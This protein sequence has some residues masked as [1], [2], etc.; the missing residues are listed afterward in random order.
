MNIRTS[1]NF[2]SFFHPRLRQTVVLAASLACL[3]PSIG[4]AFAPAERSRTGAASGHPETPPW[5]V[6]ENLG[7]ITA[8][9]FQGPAQTV[10]YIEDLHCQYEVQQ[11]IAALLEYLSGRWKIGLIGL[12]GASGP[13]DLGSLK[14]FPNRTLRAL[15]ANYFMR[16]GRLTGAEFFAVAQ[17]EPVELVGL[18]SPALYAEALKTA[19]TCL[20]SENQGMLLDLRER[21]WKYR[22]TAP[23]LRRER[24]DV[25]LGRVELANKLLNI[26]ATPREWL[27]FQQHRSEYD[28]A[29][30]TQ[31][32][33][34]P[35]GPGPAEDFSFSGL[36][37]ALAQAEKFYRISDQRSRVL[38]GQLEQAIKIRP[39][40]PAVLIGGGFHRDRVL[41]ELKRRGFN[42]ISIQ[43]RLSGG[44]TPNPYFQI[45]QG[46][47]TELEKAWFGAAGHLAPEIW[48]QADPAGY[49][50]TSEGLLDVLTTAAAANPPQAGP[51]AGATV[52]QT[53][54]QNGPARQRGKWALILDKKHFRFLNPTGLRGYAEFPKWFILFFKEREEVNQALETL[55]RPGWVF[56]GVGLGLAFLGRFTESFSEAGAGLFSLLP[57]AK[58]MGVPGALALALA[59]PAP[60]ASAHYFGPGMK[61]PV[62]EFLKHAGGKGRSLLEMAQMK[63]PVPPGFVIQD[64]IS[65]RVI[66][67]NGGRLSSGLKWKFRAQMA[68]VNRAAK[69]GFGD[70][71][72]PLLVSVRSGAD[73]SMPGMMQTLTHVGLN[74]ETVKGWEQQTGNPDYAWDSYARYIRDFGTIVFRIPQEKFE[75][76][77]RGLLVS[78][79]SKHLGKEDAQ[80]LI[81]KYQGVIR[82]AGHAFPQD[83]YE[84]LFLAV[85]RVMNS[86][87]DQRVRDFRERFQIGDIGTGVTVQE[88]VFG[89]SNQQSGS[90]VAYSRDP[91]SGAKRMT[92]N[93]KLRQRGEAIVSGQV[94]P[95]SL[96][97]IQQEISEEVYRQLASWAV[98]L[99]KKYRKILDIEFTIENGRLF[100]LQNRSAENKLSPEAKMIVWRDML[101]ETLI[102]EDEFFD[103]ITSS[104][105]L[106]ME[107]YLRSPRVP[108]N[109]SQAPAAKGEKAAVGIQAGKL[110]FGLAE[111]EACIRVG[112]RFILAVKSSGPEHDKVIQNPL[113]AGVIEQF[114][115][116]FSHAAA[117]LRGSEA[118]KPCVSGLAR[119]S[120]FSFAP[121]A[122]YIDF[123]RAGTH[124]MKGDWLTVDGTTGKIY[125]GDITDRLEAS[126]VQ[127]AIDEPM[128]QAAESPEYALYRMVL[129]WINEYKDR[130][131]RQRLNLDANLEQWFADPAQKQEWNQDFVRPLHYL[132]RFYPALCTR[133]HKAFILAVLNFWLNR[134]KVPLANYEEGVYPKEE[135]LAPIEAWVKEYFQPLGFSER[136]LALRILYTLDRQTFFRFITAPGKNHAY[137]LGLEW[138]PSGEGILKES[139]LQALAESSPE[140]VKETL[141]HASRNLA[142]YNLEQYL[143]FY[144]DNHFILSRWISLIPEPQK[145]VDV[146]CRLSPKAL[147]N[148]SYEW[149]LGVNMMFGSD[150]LKYDLTAVGEIIGAALERW[151]QDFPEGVERF[152]KEISLRDGQFEELAGQGQISEDY[153]NGLEKKYGAEALQANWPTLLLKEAGVVFPGS[154]ASVLAGGMMPWL[155]QI[156]QMR[157]GW[158]ERQ[159]AQRAWWVEGAPLMALMSFLTVGVLLGWIDAGRAAEVLAYVNVIYWGAFTPAHFLKNGTWLSWRHMDNREKANAGIAL[160]LSV[161]NIAVAVLG[162]AFLGP[163]AWVSGVV[164]GLGSHGAVN[165]IRAA[166]AKF[167]RGPSKTEKLRIRFFPARFGRSA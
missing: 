12:E 100:L 164:F 50:E 157:W 93:W 89:D 64:E 114:G 110:V 9:Y 38:V 135:E 99:E 37:Q 123:D 133:E 138:G 63:L 91:I 108:L 129:G 155:R 3:L 66:R 75:N 105:L 16:Q 143:H 28:S 102:T 70:R 76:E 19:R 24:A 71:H 120:E 58:G 46:R 27:Q 156:A 21:L 33:Q 59:Q 51:M 22:E 43:P 74:D 150:Y 31:P 25:L 140:T 14:T 90:G 23:P 125:Y 94:S 15:A 17:P 8:R 124:T 104:E 103:H 84:Q 29:H 40:F 127:E 145:I 166:V 36:D 5:N 115:A 153:F 136:V 57:A 6:P 139:M 82:A 61:K 32:F 122:E 131:H 55:N 167:R 73:T 11:T 67:E 42:F 35:S 117:L 44:N 159:Y 158:S 101:A 62:P 107:H 111:A 161:L 146:L 116:T 65:L 69:K 95:D 41:E 78:K 79:S 47:K 130:I 52:C 85:E 80:S 48:S 72:N 162:L 92:G 128:S 151:R 77:R 144:Q 53:H 83:P 49:R 149:L 7:R 142:A 26:S 68:R 119:N 2:A 45:L 118:L 148:V 97:V 10:I 141:E 54:G 60:L 81:E 134:H 87:D 152:W 20:N 1:R 154:G 109:F 160:G 163:F 98:L 96:E 137:L 30:L 86:W 112:D 18:E 121:G 113:C 106:W 34:E 56:A 39:R 13:V 165:S 4:W 88:M 126:K 132:A 147:A